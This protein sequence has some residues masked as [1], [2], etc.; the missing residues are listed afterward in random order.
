MSE[1][2]WESLGWHDLVAQKRQLASELKELSDKIIDIDRNQFR[3]IGNSIKE[4]RSLHD[5]YTERLKQIRSEVDSHNSE[6]SSVSEKLSQSR[7]FLSM[8]EARLPSEKEEELRAVVQKNQDLIDAKDYKSERERN[9]ILSRIK[10]ATMKLEAIKATHTIRDHLS[11]L[12]HESASINNTIM[13]LNEERNSIRNKIPEVNIVL[14]NLYDSKRK[15]TSQHQSY[16]TRYNS[17][18]NQFDAINARLDS[19]SEMRRKQ[20][21]EYGYIEQSDALFKVKEEAK[22]KLQ[23]G[24]KLSLEEL[25]LLYGD[26]D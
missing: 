8:M 19:M 4:Q 12:N 17:I 6:L 2:D 5:A 16:L 1:K 3:S 15:L 13:R 10:E 25:K 9:E 23:A 24:S 11:E 26:K 22:K 21:K 7:N 14:D 18:A 20:R